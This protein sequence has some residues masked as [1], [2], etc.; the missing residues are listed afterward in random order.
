VCFKETKRLLIFS[1]SAILLAIFT[2]DK[3]ER[4]IFKEEKKMLYGENKLDVLTVVDKNM[5][6]VRVK[7]Y[8]NEERREL[9][10]QEYDTAWEKILVRRMAEA[11]QRPASLSV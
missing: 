2:S 1:S 3:M 6:V 7:Y 4:I 5:N 9:T 8:D 11:M 10:K